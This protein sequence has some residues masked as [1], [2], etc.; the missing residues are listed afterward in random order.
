MQIVFSFCFFC[1]VFALL[2]QGLT[3]FAVQAV[4]AMQH[5]YYQIVLPEHTLEHYAVMLCA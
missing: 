1:L 3:L 5:Q 2:I 4:R